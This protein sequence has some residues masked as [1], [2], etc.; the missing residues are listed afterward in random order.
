MQLT[1]TTAGAD[2][3]KVAEWDN[4]A[5]RMP[6]I[7]ERALNDGVDFGTM[8]STPIVFAGAGWFVAPDVSEVRAYIQ[9]QSYEN[10]TALIDL[11]VSYANQRPRIAIMVDFL[12]YTHERGYNHRY[13]VMAIEVIKYHLFAASVGA[14]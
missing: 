13:A 4:R 7:I 6:A 2:K 9:D 12:G 3:F 14:K 11:A 5:R 10:L 8:D 1:L